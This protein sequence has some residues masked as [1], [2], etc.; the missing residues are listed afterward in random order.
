MGRLLQHGRTTRPSGPT[1]LQLAVVVVIIIPK[2]LPVVEVFD[3]HRY[4]RDL[5]I[6]S[7]RLR[8]GVPA[9]GFLSKVGLKGICIVLLLLHDPK[10]LGQGAFESPKGP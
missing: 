9:L 6:G 1:T 10:D 7:W 2:V 4:G 5:G 8:D 3:M